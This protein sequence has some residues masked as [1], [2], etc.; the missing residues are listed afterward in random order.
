MSRRYAT[1]TH[2]HTCYIIA[3]EKKRQQQQQEQQLEGNE[4]HTFNA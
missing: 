2:S 1:Y 4:N 3:L